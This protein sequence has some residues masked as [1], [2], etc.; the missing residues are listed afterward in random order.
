MI[1][2]A[3]VGPDAPVGEVGFVAGEGDGRRQPQPEGEDQ[4][5]DGEQ[6]PARCL[7]ERRGALLGLAGL[8]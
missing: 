3:E 5:G 7:G 6:G 8:D 2:V 1:V 4:R